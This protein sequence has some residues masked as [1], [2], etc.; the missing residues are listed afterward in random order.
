M[1]QIRA[2]TFCFLVTLGV[3]VVMLLELSTWQSKQKVAID[4]VNNSTE[5][6]VESSTTNT[7]AFCSGDFELIFLVLAAPGAYS[8]RRRIRATW[9]NESVLAAIRAELLFIIGNGTEINKVQE[10]NATYGDILITP[11]ADGYA[12]LTYKVKSVMISH[13]FSHSFSFSTPFE[14]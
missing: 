14:C 4:K 10:E 8:Q 9:G 2:F 11:F 7:P 3:S 6:P 5:V 12:Q 1:S 13:A